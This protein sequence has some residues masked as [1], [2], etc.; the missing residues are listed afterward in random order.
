MLVRGHEIAHLKLYMLLRPCDPWRPGRHTSSTPIAFALL[1][2]VWHSWRAP[3]D[4]TECWL[5]RVMVD[6]H[7]EVWQEAERWLAK[8]VLVC[9]VVRIGDLFLRGSQIQRTESL[10]R[11]MPDCVDW[12]RWLTRDVMAAAVRSNACVLLRFVDTAPDDV[13]MEAIKRDQTVIQ[14]IP[15]A[16]LTTAMVTLHE[17]L[18]GTSWADSDDAELD[19]E[20]EFDG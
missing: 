2:N 1:E 4:V 7:E 10:W 9:S 13:V 17:S 15:P 3:D 20:Q 8:S 11:C 18:W 19:T 6:D 16:R 12:I 5:A 14:A